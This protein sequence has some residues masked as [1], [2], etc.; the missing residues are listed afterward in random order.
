M[1]NYGFDDT[2]WKADI[3]V[4]SL[5]KANQVLF[6]NKNV[7]PSNIKCTGNRRHGFCHMA[8]FSIWLLLIFITIIHIFL[9]QS[10]G[11]NFIA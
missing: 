11:A 7:Q 3:K 4:I 6:N 8:H 10:A 9:F 2:S 1:H 5:Y